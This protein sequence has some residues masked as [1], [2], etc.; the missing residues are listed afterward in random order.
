[1]SGRRLPWWAGWSLALVVAALCAGLGSWQLQRM[2]AK[3]ALLDASARVL[4]ERRAQP[5]AVA[6]DPGRARDYD[7]TAGRGHFASLPAVL[8][9]NQ[10]RDSRPGVRAYRVFQPEDGGMPLLLELGWLPLPG[11]R[12]LPQ[13]PV[14]AMEAAGL[15]AGMPAPGMAADAAAIPEATVR[16]ATATATAEDRPMP[17]SG[18]LLPP[19]SPGLVAPTV[20]RQADGDLLLVALDPAVVAG[21]LGLPALAPRILRLDPALPMGYARDLELLPNT[22]PPERHLGYAVQWFALAIAV[23]AIAALLSWRARR[24]R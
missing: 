8:L 1:M 4:A 7:W 10:N 23:L 14:P 3:Q 6:A 17:V 16:A 2:H 21:A 19:P 9:D 18:L 5:L 11:D 15:A 13:V 22:L 20:Q 24:R 12:R